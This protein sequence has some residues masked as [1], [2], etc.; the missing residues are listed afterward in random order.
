MSEPDEYFHSFQ[1]GRS[2]ASS[3]TR[4]DFRSREMFSITKINPQDADVA[5][6]L[7]LAWFSF[8]D[9]GPAIRPQRMPHAEEI[10]G[11]SDVDRWGAGARPDQLGPTQLHSRSSTR[12]GEMMASALD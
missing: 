8:T 4:Y 3:T 6:A 2:E 1:L 11:E 9:F 5:H 10:S 7:E 12:S